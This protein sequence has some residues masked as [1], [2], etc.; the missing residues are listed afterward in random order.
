MAVGR[1]YRHSHRFKILFNTAVYLKLIHIKI[2]IL[3]YVLLFSIILLPKQSQL[4]ELSERHFWYHGH[5]TKIM[6]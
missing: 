3:M 5:L 2:I 6:S 4:G 1:R